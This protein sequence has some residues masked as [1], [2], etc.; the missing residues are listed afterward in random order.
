MKI[1]VKKITVAIALLGFANLAC[2]EWL[3]LG[4]SNDGKTTYYWNNP[5]PQRNGNIAK[6]WK[7]ADESVTET[8]LKVN[9]LSSK[10]LSEYDC[11]N[12]KFRIASVY[13]HSKNMGAGEIVYTELTHT[14]W[15]ELP[16]D[17]I[18]EMYSKVACKRR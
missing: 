2:A 8:Y 18:A 17:S 4:T 7:M 1:L 10:D 12:Q 9:Y 13:L 3:K 15:L 6:L 16:P 14:P 5:P 11:A